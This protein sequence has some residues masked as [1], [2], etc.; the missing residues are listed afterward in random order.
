MKLENLLKN[1]EFNNC[2][3]CHNI[4]IE[5]ITDHSGSVKSGSLFVA[6]KGQVDDGHDFL[7]HVV[8]NKA[9]AVVISEDEKTLIDKLYSYGYNGSI[10]TTLNTRQLLVKLLANFYNIFPDQLRIFGITGTNGKTTTCALLYKIF[11]F[12]NKK[13]GKFTTTEFNTG[14][15]EGESVMTTPDVFTLQSGLRQMKDH[16]CDVALVEVSSH[17]IDQHRIDPLQIYVAV[18]TNIT[19]DHLDYHKN[20]TNYITAKRK[21]FKGL[22]KESFAVLN[23]D[24]KVFNEFTNATKANVISYGIENIADFTACDIKSS[25]DGTRFKLIYSETSIDIETSLI[26]IYNVY[27]ILAAVSSAY[28]LGVKPED[29]IKAIGSFESV[30]GRLQEIS[31]K[32]FKIFIDYAH[33]P[34]ALEKAL[35]AL[36]SN[37]K[38]RL[39]LVFGCGGDRDKQKRPIM[40]KIASLYSDYFIITNDNPR[41]EDPE[42][43]AYSIKKGIISNNNDFDVNLDRKNAIH[44]AINMAKKN[45]IVIIAGK[46]HEKYQIFANERVY[47]DDTNIAKQTIDESNIS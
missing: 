40:G 35:K 14:G 28:A 6:V 47:F 19:Q 23:K 7:Q 9:S 13:V 41:S 20:I 5:H 4:D 38:G 31:N 22:S 18:L 2:I 32:D 8:K 26:G 21:L 10:I 24:D 17:G 16:G 27:N 46:G 29:T 30:Q 39:I 33:T 36:K 12:Q 34:D 42:K 37:C 43:I 1:T 44:Q 45:D 15:K 25:I 3:N 11:N